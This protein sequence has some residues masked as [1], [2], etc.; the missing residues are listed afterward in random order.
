M[1]AAIKQDTNTQILQHAVL[2]AIKG[3]AVTNPVLQRLRQTISGKAGLVITSYDR[4]HTRH[5]RS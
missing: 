5:N 3:K 1:G 2:E 4:M